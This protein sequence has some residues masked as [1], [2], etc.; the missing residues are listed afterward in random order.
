M[1]FASHTPCDYFPRR[2]HPWEIGI[3]LTQVAPTDKERIE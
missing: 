2:L 1:P 3:A